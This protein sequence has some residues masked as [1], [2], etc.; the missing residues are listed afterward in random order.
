M[1]SFNMATIMDLTKHC[2][3]ISSCMPVLKHFAVLE[4]LFFGAWVK[5]PNLDCANEFHWVY[6]K[7]K[8]QTNKTKS[9]YHCTL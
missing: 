3:R 8:K 1:T 2:T 6:K 5:W 7:R 4:T 9:L